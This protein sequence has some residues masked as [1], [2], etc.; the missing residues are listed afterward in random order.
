MTIKIKLIL[1]LSGT[2][3][4]FTLSLIAIL[5]Y[6]LFQSSTLFSNT[7]AAYN[8]SLETKITGGKLASY[9]EGDNFEKYYSEVY[10][11]YQFVVSSYNPLN[12]TIT[13]I[14]QNKNGSISFDL[15]TLRRKGFNDFDYLTQ[16]GGSIKNKSFQEAIDL[17]KKYDLSKEN[18][19][20]SN[21]TV[22]PAP[23][24][25]EVQKIKA[26]QDII[27]NP[28]YVERYNICNQISIKEDDIKFANTGLQYEDDQT[29]ALNKE[30]RACMKILQN[31]FPKE[32]EAD[33]G[34]GK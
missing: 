8:T 4:I 30:F 18:P 23:T 14:I 10:N 32:I 15:L 17:A 22:F 5:F 27:D 25:E 33:F 20:P 26:K 7:K 34:T 29:R 1:I 28:K 9:R 13:L 3:V 31:D 24:R 6:P 2:L 11:G 12:P 19:D 16:N 21:I